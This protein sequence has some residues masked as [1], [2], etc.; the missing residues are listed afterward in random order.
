MAPIYI[1]CT[2]HSLIEIGKCQENC[3]LS[4]Q[5]WLKVRSHRPKIASINGTHNISIFSWCMVVPEVSI[6]FQ[7][8]F[9][10]R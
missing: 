6:A 5:N 10:N 7:L 3:V 4:I 1:A 8:Y 9:I 2:K